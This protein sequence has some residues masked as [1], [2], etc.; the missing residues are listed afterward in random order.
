MPYRS[1]TLDAARQAGTHVTWTGEA[2]ETVS[3]HIVAFQLDGAL[4]Q[5]AAG[6]LQ[7]VKPQELTPVPPPAT[8]PIPEPA[9]TVQQTSHVP[10]VSGKWS[11]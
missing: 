6:K 10:Q 5:T 2:G 4:C 1:E 11:E 7:H 3:G 8:P 9:R